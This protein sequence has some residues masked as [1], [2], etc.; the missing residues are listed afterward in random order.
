MKYNVGYDAPDGFRTYLQQ[1][2][3]HDTA[4]MYLAKWCAL[5]LND[6]GT[7]K[8]YPNGKGFYPFRNPRIVCK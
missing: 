1:W 6:D 8:P 2:V 7:G 5:Y 4:K 3:D